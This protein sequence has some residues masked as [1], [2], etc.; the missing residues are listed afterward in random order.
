MI[1]LK[2]S[3]L[4]DQRVLEGAKLARLSFFDGSFELVAL[5]HH[6]LDDFQSSGTMSFE[7]F[8]AVDF[9]VRIENIGVQNKE[10]GKRRCS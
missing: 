8:C 5:T 10:I 4:A 2:I 7:G 9:R 6:F 3:N 1:D